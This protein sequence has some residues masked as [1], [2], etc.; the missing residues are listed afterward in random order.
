MWKGKVEIK[1]LYGTHPLNRSLFW[2]FLWKR[3]GSI[4]KW[5]CNGKLWFFFVWNFKKNVVIGYLQSSS[6]LDVRNHHSKKKHDATHK[7]SLNQNFSEITFYKDDKNEVFH[8]SQMMLHPYQI[9]QQQMW[10][11]NTLK[12]VWR[13]ITRKKIWIPSEHPLRKGRKDFKC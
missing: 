11:N 13:T 4:R 5:F 3:A 1:Q 12:V 6:S 7:H 9:H 2:F 10:M 8:P